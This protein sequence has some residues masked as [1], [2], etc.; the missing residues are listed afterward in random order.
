MKE[1]IFNTFFAL[2]LVCTLAL[3]VALAITRDNIA[4][5]K[6]VLANPQTD[7]VYIHDTTYIRQPRTVATRVLDSLL[8]AAVPEPQNDT[9]RLTDTVYIKVPIEQKHYTGEDY[10]AWVSGYRPSLDSLKIYRQSAQITNT[11]PIKPATKSKRWGVGVQVGYGMTV[12]P[13]PELRPYIGVGISY[14]ILTF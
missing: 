9:V 11:I 1:T 4:H 5:L 14:N 3:S 10:D 12:A 6:E 7:T 2:L 8:L 13:K